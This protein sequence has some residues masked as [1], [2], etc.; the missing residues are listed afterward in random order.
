MDTIYLISL[1]YI[2]GDGEP[3]KNPVFSC[4]TE[5]GAKLRCNTIYVGDLKNSVKL[6]EASLNTLLLT[7]VQRRNRIRE[8]SRLKSEIE[9]AEKLKTYPIGDFSIDIIKFDDI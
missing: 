7:K 1:I 5:N 2:D 8:I 4:K 3:H 6:W 9:Y